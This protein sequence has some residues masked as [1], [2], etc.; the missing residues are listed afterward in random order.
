MCGPGVGALR[1]AAMTTTPSTRPTTRASKRAGNAS[2]K[3]STS[4]SIATATTSSPHAQAGARKIRARRAGIATTAVASLARSTGA[5]P[6]LLLLAGAPEAAFALLVVLERAEQLRLAEVRP[7][8]LGHVQLGVGDLPQ[9]EVGDAHFAAGAD[10]QVGIRK[11]GGAEVRGERRLVDRLRVEPAVARGAG[12]AARRRDDVLAAP[13]TDAQTDVEAAIVARAL[14][15]AVELVSDRIGQAVHV[16]DSVHAHLVLHE[17]VHLGAQIAQQ[18][19]HQ[20]VD[21]APRPLPVLGREGEQAEE[22]DTEPARCFD[23]GAH[24]PLAAPMPL[25]ARQ[26]APLRPPPVAIHDDGDV[27][28]KAGEIEAGGVECRHLLRPP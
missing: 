1:A 10:E 14:D 7:Q 6:S 20:R 4:P 26:S 18:Q 19:P 17:L 9:E 12:D 28:R 16:A 11:A 3:Y 27:A 15:H 13:V 24:R 23:H 21:L 8:G 2:H 25:D 5:F 22:G